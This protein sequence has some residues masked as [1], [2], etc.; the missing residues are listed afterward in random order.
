[1]VIGYSFRDE[2]ITKDIRDAADHGN[3]RLFIIDPFG[4]DVLQKAPQHEYFE[5]SRRRRSLFTDLQPLLIGASR[6]TMQEVFGRDPVEHG[7]V[8]RFFAG[9]AV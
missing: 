2:H 3:L 1:V 5:T 4:V 6:R 7:K 9:E 8:M